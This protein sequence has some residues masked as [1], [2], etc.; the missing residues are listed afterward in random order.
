MTYFVDINRST[1]NLYIISEIEDAD[2]LHD[3]RGARQCL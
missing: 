2:Q 1:L 3:D